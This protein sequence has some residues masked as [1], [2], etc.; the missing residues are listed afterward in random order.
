MA[1]LESL[2]RPGGCVGRKAF[3][4]GFTQVAEA[5]ITGFFDNIDH[6]VLMEQ[7]GRRVSDRSTICDLALMRL[8]LHPGK[9]RA[10][11]LREVREGFDSL[12]C[13]LHARMSG[14]LWE[15]LGIVRYY[16][17]RWASRRLMKRLR[18]K[19]ATAPVAIARV[20]RSKC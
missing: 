15:R 6:D 12:G 17:H 16:L 18:E 4:E 9:T 3:I 13:H 8:H 1:R 19:S 5:D 14:R 2:V 10:V 11:D 20:G 7:V